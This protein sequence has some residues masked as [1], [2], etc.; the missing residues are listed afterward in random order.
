MAVTVST[1][2]PTRYRFTTQEYE[3][4]G[5]IGILGEDDRVELI[6]GEIIQM[7]ALGNKHVR[8]VN[9]INRLL[10]PALSE[11][12]IVSIQNP[13]VIPEH[14][15]PEPDV[16]V[17]KPEAENRDSNPMSEDV[18]VLIE[19]SDTTLAYDRDV[20]LPIYARAGIPETLIADLNGQVVVRHTEPDDQGYRATKTF[21]R[22]DSIEFTMLPSLTISVD[23]ILS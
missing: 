19:V 17:L 16:A 4:M 1:Q 9:R 15:E 18:L 21:R 22:G 3:R 20:K 7:S 8:C 6:N 23:D 12:A 5:E 2:T 10:V 11:Q 14:N 13:V